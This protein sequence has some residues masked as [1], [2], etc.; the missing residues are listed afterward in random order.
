MNH[1]SIIVI[2][3]FITSCFSTGANIRETTLVGNCQKLLKSYRGKTGH[4]MAILNMNNLEN[5]NSMDSDYI[6]K[7]VFREVFKDGRFRVVERELIMGIFKELK[8]Q[9][10][11]IIAPSF[12]SKISQLTGAKLLLIIRNKYGQIDMR[13]VSVED[14]IVFAYTS[15]KLPFQ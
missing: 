4:T 10:T 6:N 2:L 11:G 3:L 14:G 12:T 7:T 13:I 1:K 5:K 9:Q 15:F 8:L